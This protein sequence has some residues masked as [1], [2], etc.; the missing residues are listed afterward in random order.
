MAERRS[1]RKER[2]S[3]VACSNVREG[4]LLTCICRKMQ[5]KLWSLLQQ[6]RAGSFILQVTVY[7]GRRPYT[8]TRACNEN[9]DKEKVKNLWTF[10]KTPRVPCAEK[11]RKKNRKTKH[12]VRDRLSAITG[13]L[14][15]VRGKVVWSHAFNILGWSRKDALCS[16]AHACMFVCAGCLLLS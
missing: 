7:R 16:Y 13:V 8:G 6:L 3:V 11:E 14:E 5:R 2:F 15:K 1:W 9:N 4:D 10:G 12:Q